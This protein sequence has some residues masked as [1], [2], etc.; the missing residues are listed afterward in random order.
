VQFGFSLFSGERMARGSNL[1]Q[2][3]NLNSISL[4][5]TLFFIS[6]PEQKEREQE[7]PVIVV[8]TF[9]MNFPKTTRWIWGIYSALFFFV[10]L[11]KKHLDLT[12]LYLKKVFL[13][14]NTEPYPLI[15]PKSL[16][17]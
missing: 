3:F 14:D 4:T 2:K 17:K 1:Q 11:W 13:P 16:L 5:I 15:T 12:R 9:L 7:T 10:A 6:K 8:I